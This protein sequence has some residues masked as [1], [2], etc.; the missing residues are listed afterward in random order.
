VLSTLVLVAAGLAVASVATYLFLSSFLMSRLDQELHSA[1]GPVDQALDQV[2]S[3][4]NTFGPP[5]GGGAAIPAGTY[6][7]FLDTSGK[8]YPGAAVVFEYGH[9][10]S[11]P[12]PPR[13]PS[14]LPGSSTGPSAGSTLFSANSAD[15]TARYRCIAVPLTNTSNGSVAGSLVVAIPLSDT[16]GTLHRLLLV[17]LLAS[18]AVLVAA[19]AL[20]LWLVRVGLRP[21][22]E[23]GDTAGAIAAG[24]LS[25]RVE[26]ADDSTEV[27]RLGLSLN[28][29]LGQ[30]EEAFS[31]RAESEER[32][33]R[34]VADASHE[35]RTPLTSIR[36][37]AELFRRGASDRPEDLARSMERIEGEA[38]RMGVMVE[39]LLLLARLDQGVPLAKQRLDLAAVAAQAV[40]DARAADP[41]MPVAFDT[42]GPAF[43]DGDE[44]RLK[45][46]L[47]N[48]LSNARVH[49]PSGTAV[50]VTVASGD[51]VTVTVADE[52]PGISG[53]MAESVFER[54]VRIDAA[55]T[56]ENG[57]AGLGLSIAREIAVAHG[58]SLK[59]V[60][61]PRGARFVL[62]LPR[63]DLSDTLPPVPDARPETR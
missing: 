4:G 50:Q 33:R 52:G 32:L 42:S 35:L 28:A 63:A 7:A 29:M 25:R 41:A 43:V 24:D 14:G 11:K 60:P 58:G 49:T 19:G 38:N 2:T 6:G 31:R 8:P 47:D 23:I 48:L 37:Y 56:R 57:G 34:F 13:L 21:L 46:V 39:D 16:L 3:G 10:S 45:Q 59:L 40:Q 62:E 44:L 61:N 36:G 12:S 26:R 54:F 18:I 22:R 30:I 51:R 1:L 27:G 17:E 15:G 5:I 53:E 20:A 55:R 9:G